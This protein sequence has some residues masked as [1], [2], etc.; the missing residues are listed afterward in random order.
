MNDVINM[1]AKP[2]TR[3]RSARVSRAKVRSRPNVHAKHPSI[4]GEAQ[5]D[6]AKLSRFK[7]EAGNKALEGLWSGLCEPEEGSVSSREKNQ[8]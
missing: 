7:C 1:W 3:L 4:V 8:T 5:A 6:I 2:E